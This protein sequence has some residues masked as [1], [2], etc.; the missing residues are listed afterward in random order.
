[1]RRIATLP[2]AAVLVLAGCGDDGESGPAAPPTEA[3]P[4]AQP[5]PKQK[6]AGTEIRVAGS[7]FGPMLFDARKQAIYVFENDARNKS[8][9]YGECAE[10]WPPVYTEG[11]PRAADG[12]RQSLLGTAERRDGRRQVTYAGKPLYYYAHEG[13][14]E[15]RCHDVNLNGGFWWVV[16]PGGKRRP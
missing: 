2:V 3:A 1:M 14:G 16:G 6:P 5:E 15:V 7:E 8:V 10:A 4:Q 11:E 9:C 12:A 13:P